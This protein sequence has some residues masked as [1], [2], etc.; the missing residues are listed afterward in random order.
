MQ[1]LL[2]RLQ[3]TTS[4]V[5]SPAKKR[6]KL[7]ESVSYL[8][9]PPVLGHLISDRPASNAPSAD[10]FY[11]LVLLAEILAASSLPGSLDLISRLLDTLN[12]V[13]HYEPPA[14]GDKSY[15]EQLLMS[16]VENAAQNVI[17]SLQ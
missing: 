4:Q 11:S 14:Q 13:L 9:G 15:I 1:H 2:M 17:V 7:D 12:S 3:P 16:A 6:A 10:F 8:S 5:I